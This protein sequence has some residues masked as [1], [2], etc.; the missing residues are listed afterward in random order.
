MKHVRQFTKI[1]YNGRC[2]LCRS[3]KLQ[4][5]SKEESRDIQQGLNRGSHQ[6]FRKIVPQLKFEPFV[7]SQCLP[8]PASKVRESQCSQP[9][10][11]KWSQEDIKEGNKSS[12]KSHYHLQNLAFCI[13]SQ[14][15]WDLHIVKNTFR[16]VSVLLS[17]HDK[18]LNKRE[19]LIHL[20]HEERIQYSGWYCWHQECNLM[21]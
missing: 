1:N 8:L 11:E 21:K 14:N 20:I 16:K 12:T 9:A 4:G 15:K 18:N 19:L 5:F 7:F 2:M 6:N 3:I 13:Y 10:T 17:I